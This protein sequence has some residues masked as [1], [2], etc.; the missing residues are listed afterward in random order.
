M[1]G[2]LLLLWNRRIFMTLQYV[3]GDK[4]QHISVLLD[5]VPYSQYTCVQYRIF[6]FL[7]CWIVYGC[8]HYLWRW[9][10]WLIQLLFKITINC[11]RKS[12]SNQFCRL[13]CE[14]ELLIW[15]TQELST[16]VWWEDNFWHTWQKDTWLTQ[17][18]IHETET[19]TRS[20][21]KMKRRLEKQGFGSHNPKNCICLIVPSFWLVG[22]LGWTHASRKLLIKLV[23][24]YS[25]SP[26]VRLNSLHCLC[27]A[28]PRSMT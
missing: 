5:Y 2:W 24:V 28:W 16:H 15:C 1:I 7:T 10:I 23:H 6:D 13:C 12:T 4:W 26:I 18:I 25:H 3:F 8:F 21:I 11:N 17:Y 22:S 14:D 27:K 20:D 19:F 9:N